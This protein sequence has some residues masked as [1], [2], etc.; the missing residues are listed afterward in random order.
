M[1]NTRMLSTATIH[2]DYVLDRV[3]DVIQNEQCICCRA[4]T[5][6]QLLNDTRFPTKTDDVTTAAFDQVEKAHLD[7][8][9]IVHGLHSQQVPL[10]EITGCHRRQCHPNFNKTTMRELASAESRLMVT[11]HFNPRIHNMH[12][13]YLSYC[14]SV[15]YGVELVSYDDTFVMNRTLEYVHILDSVRNLFE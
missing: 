11:L 15:Q 2:W 12:M 1:A 9:N 14:E 8:L 4:F 10:M 3:E 13:C 7:L 6:Y 5:Y